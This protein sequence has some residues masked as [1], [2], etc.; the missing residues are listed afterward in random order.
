LACYDQYRTEQAEW[1]RSVVASE[2]F[3]SAPLKIAFC[4]IPPEAKGWHGA[5]EI[6][7][8]FVPILNEGGLDLMLSGHIH[9]YRLTEAG[10]NGCQF[11]VLCNPNVCRLDATA[12][13]NGVDIKI[14]DTQANLL[15]SY[16][17][18]K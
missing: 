10:E 4:H 17:L 5:A 18:K 2:E 6:L 8:L 14:F 1:L 13:A 15:H 12:T 16:Q 11:P 3:R 7:R 9:K